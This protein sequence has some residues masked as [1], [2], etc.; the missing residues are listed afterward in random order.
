[1]TTTSLQTKQRLVVT[2]FLSILLSIYCIPTQAMPR[3]R[4]LVEPAFK[5]KKGRPK[6]EPKEYVSVPCSD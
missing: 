2:L 6:F 4:I 1:M 3:G 5:K